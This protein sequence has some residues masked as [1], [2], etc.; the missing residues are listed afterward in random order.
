VLIPA[1]LYTKVLLTNTIRSTIRPDVTQAAGCLARNYCFGNATEPLATKW[2]D[3]GIV[4]ML[5]LDDQAQ[6]NPLFK[7]PAFKAEHQ[8]MHSQLTNGSIVQVHHYRMDP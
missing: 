8:I 6:L 2:N 5:T 1:E 7:S 3:W 4:K